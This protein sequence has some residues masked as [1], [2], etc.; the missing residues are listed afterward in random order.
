M[1]YLLP[2][3]FPLAGTLSILIYSKFDFGDAHTHYR[4]FVALFLVRFSRRLILFDTFS[5]TK[6]FSLCFVENRHRK[7]VAGLDVAASS[8]AMNQFRLFSS[9]SI[10]IV[11]RSRV[12]VW[13]LSDGATVWEY[14]VLAFSAFCVTLSAESEVLAAFYADLCYMY[15]AMC[16]ESYIEQ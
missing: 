12:C 3:T 15:L 11:R 14:I 9:L 1:K 2:N 8:K 16:V 4:S 13:A 10:S 7:F 5:R 6:I